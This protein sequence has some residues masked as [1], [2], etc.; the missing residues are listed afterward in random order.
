MT[1]SVPGTYCFYLG[2]SQYRHINR[3]GWV[4]LLGCIACAAVAVLLDVQLWK[5]YTHEFVPYLKWQDGLAFMLG[6]IAFICLG[7]SV[8]ILRF[9]H[10]LREGYKKGMLTLDGNNALLV[11]DLSPENL[12]SIFWIMN[13]AFWCFF[14]VLVGFFPVI[15]IGWTMHITIVPLA[16]VATGL[17][18]IFSA[19]GFILSMVATFFIVVGS[20]GAATLCRKLGS[21][22]GYS[23]S[24]STTLRIDNFV[25]TIIQPGMP[26]AMV[27]LNLLTSED[28]R[29]LLTLLYTRWQAS[30]H[31]W[32]PSLGEE[33]ALALEEAERSE[34][35]TILV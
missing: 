18:V 29:S 25:L 23:V 5:T 11:R 26:E 32:S 7:G 28:Q 2:G 24:D 13:S 19:A 21:S 20:V 22:S 10:A 35:S 14:V 9:Q 17:A 8:F 16:V 33:I 34:Q 31:I 6:F 12:I 4:F 27:D 30:E 3:R 15:L 1:Q